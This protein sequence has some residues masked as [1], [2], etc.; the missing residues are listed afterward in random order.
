MAKT[1]LM[2]KLLRSTWLYFLKPNVDS[3]FTIK[4]YLIYLGIKRLSNFM[5]QSFKISTNII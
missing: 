3:G 5:N 1:G 4:V 2:Q